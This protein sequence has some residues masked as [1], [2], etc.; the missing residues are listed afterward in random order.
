MSP[1]EQKRHKHSPDNGKRGKYALALILL[2]LLILAAAIIILL[3]IYVDS[4]KMLVPAAVIYFTIS[5]CIFS[6][7]LDTILISCCIFSIWLDRLK[8]DVHVVGA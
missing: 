5:C 6:L 1:E 8:Q 3:F 7:V 4:L 2:F